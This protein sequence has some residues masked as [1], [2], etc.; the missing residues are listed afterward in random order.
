MN[1]KAFIDPDV[2]DFI[3]DELSEEDHAFLRDS[4]MLEELERQ[5]SDEPIGTVQ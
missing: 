2:D 3:G 4:G 1:E 5:A